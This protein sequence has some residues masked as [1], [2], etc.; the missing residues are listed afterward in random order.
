MP[1]KVNYRKLALEKYLSICAYCGF[2]I[3]AVLEVAHL[4]GNRSHNDV[5]N[6]AVLCPTCHRMHDIDLITTSTIR[7]TRERMQRFKDVVSWKKNMKD[8]ATKAALTRKRRAAAR[9][10]VETRRQRQNASA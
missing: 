3:E 4:D 1:K 10:A 7:A 6:L 8:A 5:D 9:K 2:G